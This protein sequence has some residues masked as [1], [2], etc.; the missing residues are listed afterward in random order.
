M[1]K[2]TGDLICIPDGGYCLRH[3]T[4]STGQ[5]LSNRRI[6]AENVAFVP[7]TNTNEVTA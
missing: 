6:D 7:M 3:N 2:F 4:V 5:T 1:P